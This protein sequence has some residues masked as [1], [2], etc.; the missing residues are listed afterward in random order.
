MDGSALD[1]VPRWTPVHRRCAD[2]A[3]VPEGLDVAPWSTEDQERLERVCA[4]DPVELTEWTGRLD[5][6]GADTRDVI[7]GLRTLGAG[8]LGG[9]GGVDRC[10]ELCSA[11][12][13]RADELCRLGEGV[14]AVATQLETVLSEL[15]HRMSRS[16]HSV[17]SPEPQPDDPRWSHG[18]M[19]RELR[20][21]LHAADRTCGAA[22]AD[23]AWGWAPAEADRPWVGV[24]PD[25][26]FAPGPAPAPD[27]WAEWRPLPDIPADAPMLPGTEGTRPE[28]DTGVRIAQL[29][30]TEAS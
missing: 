28:T 7:E 15:A 8:H 1:A 6:V 21:C 16:A 13:D 14:R 25:P 23:S 27:S 29:P 18:T 9:T 2:R 24:R 5:E 30:D 3:S 12:E 20:A 4:L 26:V 10:A 17:T 19:L 22:S 11:I